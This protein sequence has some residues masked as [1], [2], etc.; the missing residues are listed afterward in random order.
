MILQK[1]NSHRTNVL[2]TQASRQD[3]PT[4]TIVLRSRYASDAR[5]RLRKLKTAIRKKIVDENFFSPITTNAFQYEYQDEKLNLFMEWLQLQEA[6]GILELIRMPNVLP[7]SLSPRP[8]SD[9]Y[10]WSAYQ[11]GI[12]QTRADLR[13]FNMQIP[14]ATGGIGSLEFGFNAP[15]HNES[16]RVLYTRNFSQLKGVTAEMDTQISRILSQGMIDGKNPRKMATEISK[17]IDTIGIVR[18][19][20]IARTEVI[21]AFNVASLNDLDLMENFLDETIYVQWLTALDERV[22]SSHRLRHG[23]I[24]KREDARKL[25]GEPNCRCA[26]PPYLPS[27]EGSVTDDQWG[28]VNIER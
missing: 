27:I 9:V 22:R 4:R 3:D 20:R 18:A 10:I 1:K 15:I 12:A 16:V 13:G 5:N 23:K 8:W 2:I 11:K 19:N 6:E 21:N 17:K 7:V 14:I 24:Y 25:I 28:P 26:C